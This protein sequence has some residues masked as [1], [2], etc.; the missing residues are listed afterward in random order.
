MKDLYELLNKTR[1]GH[2]QWLKRQACR[3][4]EAIVILS[5]VQAIRMRHP[6]IGMRKLY[7]LVNPPGIGR[8]KFIKLL[9]ENG[10][11]LNRVKNYRRTTY[12]I[13]HLAYDNKIEGL[14]LDGVN[15]L[16]VSDI[17]YYTNRKRHYYLTFIMDVYSRKIVGYAASDS[18]AAQSNIKA[19]KMALK[20]RKPCAGMIHH[21]DRGSQYIHHEY[22][23]LLKINGIQISMGNKAWQN[24]HAE[25]INGTIKNEYLY[26]KGEID[27]LKSLQKKLTQQV[28]LYNEERPHQELPEELSP[29]QFEQLAAQIE[30]D[31]KVKINY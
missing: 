8:D 17:T 19:M 4:L 20:N 9:R 11:A 2:H 1:Q 16:W 7:R 21:S 13:A 31:Y 18:L 29:S 12:S 15:Q 14:E 5:D 27:S 26:P 28:K 10:L 30:I 23:E 3:K 22:V 24:A 25:R 6:R